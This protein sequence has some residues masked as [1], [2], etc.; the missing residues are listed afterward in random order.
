MK[1][2]YPVEFC[3]AVILLLVIRGS[4]NARATTEEM[5]TNNATNSNVIAA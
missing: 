1:M 5:N 3:R 4:N 2:T